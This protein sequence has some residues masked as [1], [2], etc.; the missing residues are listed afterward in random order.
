MYLLNT[1]DIGNSDLANISRLS[2]LLKSRPIVPVR[3]SDIIFS[4]LL[5][6]CRVQL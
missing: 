4:I 6:K 2:F 1:I 5:E 3:L